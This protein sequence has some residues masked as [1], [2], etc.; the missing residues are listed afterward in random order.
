[1][2]TAARKEEAVNAAFSYI[3][4]TSPATDKDHIPDGSKG[5]LQ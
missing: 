3:R 4:E 5:A 1:V 2:P